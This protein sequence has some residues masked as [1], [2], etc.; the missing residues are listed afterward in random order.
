MRR[1]DANTYLRV[2]ECVAT[3]RPGGGGGRPIPELLSRCRDQ[4]WLVFTIDT[5]VC[6]Y[7]D[8]QEDMVDTLR[9]ADVPVRWFT[10]HRQ[11]PRLVPDRAVAVR[12]SDAGHARGARAQSLT[13]LREI[14]DRQ[15]RRG[16]A[17]FVPTMTAPLSAA[18]VLA[19]G[20]LLGAVPFAFI[21]GSAAGVDLRTV[22][23]GNVGAGNLRRTVGIGPA[24]AAAVLDGLKG[25]A[26]VIIARRLGFDDGV[27]AA[28]G[29]AA[30]VGHN[31]SVYLRSRAGRGLA[32]AVG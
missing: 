10:V 14:T 26:P 12:G 8:E 16:P 3:L 27:A 7:P 25:L 23:T 32:T 19:L 18:A 24:V 5:D 15:A 6:F 20:Y 2:M 30:V 1:F 9:D 31:W 21:L 13:S 29:V 28:S 4:D 22:G 11:G 17:I